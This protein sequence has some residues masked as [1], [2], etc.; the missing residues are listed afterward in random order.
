[1]LDRRLLSITG[2][3]SHRLALFKLRRLELLRGVSSWFGDHCLPDIVERV[4]SLVLEGEDWGEELAWLVM[5][6]GEREVLRER[7]KALER[8][9]LR[10]LRLSR[11]IWAESQ[12]ASPWESFEWV[13]EESW[14]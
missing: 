8:E 4:V 12:M 5:S 3:S 6:E 11:E 14:D 13:E 2:M 10:Q 7:E 1:M 9:E